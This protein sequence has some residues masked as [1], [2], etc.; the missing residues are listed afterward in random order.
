MLKSILNSVW[1]SRAARIL[2]GAIFIYASIDKLRYPLEF[3]RIIDA[4]QLL[5]ENL[6]G[7]VAAV[8]PFL[9]L[10][11]G[12]FL[13]I[14]FWVL[15]S[16]VWVGLLLIAFMIGMGQAY[17]RGLSIDCGC[18]SVTGSKSGITTWTVLRD[19]LILLVWLKAF[20]Y[21]KRSLAPARKEAIG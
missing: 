16:L 8:L 3:A 17:F 11:C 1:V 14:G 21:Y 4:Y 5:P 13:I 7:I 19:V 12:I 20:L 10:I 15:P 6:V 2:L 18:F 9:E